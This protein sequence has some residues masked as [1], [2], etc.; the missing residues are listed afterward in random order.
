M[1]ISVHCA[2]GQVKLV[3]APSG[4]SPIDDRVSSSHTSR[5][6]RIGVVSDTLALL[7]CKVGIVSRAVLGQCTS[8]LC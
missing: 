7:G 2:L 8:R 5:R 3:V 4:N 1:V 6:N